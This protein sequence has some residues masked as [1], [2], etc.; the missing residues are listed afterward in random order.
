MKLFLLVLVMAGN[1]IFYQ[2]FPA[3]NQAALR[4][5]VNPPHKSIKATATLADPDYRL[6]QF[7]LNNLSVTQIPIPELQFNDPAVREGTEECQDCK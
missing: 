3:K 6:Y 2:T 5:A 1:L 4:V 7:D